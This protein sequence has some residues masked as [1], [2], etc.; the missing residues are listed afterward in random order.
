[1]E[2]IETSAKKIFVQ[3]FVYGVGGLIAFYYVLLFLFTR[4]FFYPVSQFMHFQPWMSLLIVGFGIQY[5]LYRLMKHGV[6]FSAEE[7]ADAGVV[8]GAGTTVS[9]IA[10]IACCAHHAVELLP[11]LGVSAAALFFVE[12]QTELLVL[13]VVANI[14][15]SLV[16]V[17]LLTG[18]KPPGEF[19]RNMSY[20][21]LRIQ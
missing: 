20:R 7:K 12:F 8:T 11:F 2:K 5:G 6:R 19:V 21:I 13:G 9:G 17:W 16:M 18:K 10:M 4:D 15:G 14:M 3:G 1:M